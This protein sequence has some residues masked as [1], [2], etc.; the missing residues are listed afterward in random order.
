MGTRNSRFTPGVARLHSIINEMGRTMVAFSGG[1]D[2]TYLLRKALD[3]LGK[4]AVLAVHIRSPLQA[5]GEAQQ[6][7]DLARSMGIRVRSVEKDPLIIEEV[8]GNHP[9]RCYHC[10]MAVFSTLMDMA[11]RLEIPWVMDGTNADD[12]DHYRPGLNALAELKVRS[13]LREAGLRKAQI[14]KECR[15]MGLPVWNRPSA[16][17]LV[18]RFPYGQQITEVDIR[19]VDS[20]ESLL[21]SMGFDTV[22]LRVHEDIARIEVPP[23]RIG[24]L[25]GAAQGPDLVPSL[26]ILG[27]RYVTVDM[28]GFRSG[29]MDEALVN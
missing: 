23:D 1:V 2:S 22:R 7:I 20:G 12:A 24:E 4:D 15:K 3:V 9:D 6:A 21:K 13:P 11:S 25:L 19:R 8:A 16:P 18:T 27:F 29:S 17:C 10:K 5:E 14:R 26:K 28:E